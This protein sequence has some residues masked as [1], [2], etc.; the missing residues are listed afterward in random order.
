MDERVPTRFCARLQ[1]R[2]VAAPQ[3]ERVTNAHAPT[4]VELDQIIFGH[5][6]HGTPLPPWASPE[7]SDEEAALLYFDGKNGDGDPLT[8]D[9][10][11]TH[12]RLVADVLDLFM[13][14]SD[15][16]IEVLARR[17][18]F[19]LMALFGSDAES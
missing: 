11:A 6:A 17:P 7:I 16:D 8:P 19:L 2:L 15:E 9:E 1:Q 18:V 4:E 14:L 10:A 3:A 13:D 5:R 12:A